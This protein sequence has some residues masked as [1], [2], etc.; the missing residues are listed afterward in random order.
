MSKCN[1]CANT[2]KDSLIRACDRCLQNYCRDHFNVKYHVCHKANKS[3]V[4]LEK[5]N[6]I[7]SQKKV[8]EDLKRS[9]SLSFEPIKPPPSPY[10]SDSPI[11]SQSDPDVQIDILNLQAVKNSYEKQIDDLNSEFKTKM[12]KCDLLIDRLAGQLKQRQEENEHYQKELSRLQALVEAKPKK[13]KIPVR[14]W[15]N[16]SQG[17]PSKGKT[18]L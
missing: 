17:M 11:S 15:S 18:Q 6:V 14:K 2:K 13:K 5:E 12:D 4:I 9:V 3:Q 16:L 8:I 7:N 1:I 10:D